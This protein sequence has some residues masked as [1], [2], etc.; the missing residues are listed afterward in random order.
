[1][2]KKRLTKSEKKTI[3]KIQALR[4]RALQALRDRVQF[5]IKRSEELVSKIDD[6]G[7]AQKTFID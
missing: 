3:E 2:K 1:M 4:G 7:L 6:S 5:L